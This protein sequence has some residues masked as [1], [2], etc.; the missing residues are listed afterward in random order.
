MRKANRWAAFTDDELEALYL[1][2]PGRLDDGYSPTAQA[3][4]GEMFAE[5]ERRRS[6]A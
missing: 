3:L 1:A 5:L 4:H 6:D 2:L